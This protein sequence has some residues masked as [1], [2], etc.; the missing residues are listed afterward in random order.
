M[1]DSRAERTARELLGVTADAQASELTRA[2]RRQARNL[3]PDLSRDPAATER[4]RA[5]RAA[6]ELALRAA[7]ASQPHRED[8][9]PA[10][11][12]GTRQA[13][14]GHGVWVVAGPVHVDPPRRPDPMRTPSKGRS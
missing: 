14:P 3:H 8:P 11:A 13:S 6:Y 9:R 10:T 1:S 4:F 12:P 2:Y 7:L 5:L